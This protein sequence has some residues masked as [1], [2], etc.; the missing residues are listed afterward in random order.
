MYTYVLCILNYI[1]VYIYTQICVCV[2]DPSLLTRLPFGS[3]WLLIL[4]TFRVN[5]IMSPI[6]QISHS[7][8][9]C[10]IGVFCGIG[11]THYIIL[12]RSFSQW[13]FQDPKMEVLYSTI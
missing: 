2:C 3:M 9:F 5:E 12:H 7:T 1:Y 11:F 13:E 10:V 8:H 6:S 4:S